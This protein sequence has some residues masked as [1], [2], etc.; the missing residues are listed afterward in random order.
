V[1]APKLM[2]AQPL[3]QPRDLANHTLLE[4]AGATDPWSPLAAQLGFRVNKRLAFD[5]YLATLQAAS[6][7]LGVAM[8]LFPF[9]TNWVRDGRLVTPLPLR[10][11][12]VFGY[13]L[14]YRPEERERPELVVFREWLT[15]L[16]AALPPLDVPAA[17]AARRPRK[18]RTG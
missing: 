14:V 15:A 6:H 16:F 9:S 5:S 8:G 4:V 1:A 11:P 10:V 13:H 7:G 12:G 3:A 17:A 2:R 18:R